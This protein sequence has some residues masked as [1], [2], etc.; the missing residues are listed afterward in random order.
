MYLFRIVHVFEQ[1][2]VAYV[3]RVSFHALLQSETEFMRH[4]LVVLRI[5]TLISRTCIRRAAGMCCRNSVSDWS[6]AW[7]LTPST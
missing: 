7:K 5:H 3:D 6:R 4:L 1:P 2:V